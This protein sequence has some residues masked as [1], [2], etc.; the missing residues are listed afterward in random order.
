MRR[1]TTS[2]VTDPSWG[3]RSVN[4]RRL[5]ALLGAELICAVL[6]IS[7]PQLA[8][9]GPAIAS[10]VSESRPAQLPGTRSVSTPDGRTTQLVDLGATGGRAL[11]DRIAAELPG[12]TN[13][14]TAFWGSDWRR[15]ISIVVA[16]SAEQFGALAG[17]GLDI[18][19]TTTADRIMFS[20]G[21]TAMNAA[22][23]RTVLRHEL[24]HYA[25]RADTAPDAPVWL[26]EGVADYVGRPPAATAPA[27]P[28]ALPTDAELTAPG[29]GRS[30]AYDRA[31]E[32]ATY[33]AGTYG[34]DKLRA[35]YVAACGHGHPDV[36]TAILAVL[37][38]DVSKVLSR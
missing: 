13:A 34:V 8:P 19:A 18:A 21:A 7:G 37:G 20:P 15:D 32:F 33:I 28:A 2:V 25:A 16:G 35:L 1:S 14:V 23:L 27:A 17:G 22:D 11:I 9:S 4:R 6:L 10:P 26:T 12:A 30:A 5:G 3:S 29:P 36:D 24:F 31:W 38:V